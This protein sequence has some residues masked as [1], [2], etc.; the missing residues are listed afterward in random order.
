MRGWPPA[1]A[2]RWGGVRVVGGWE[3]GRGGGGGEGG[4]SEGTIMADS[5]EGGEGDDGGVSFASLF[6]N[7]TNP[8]FL[9]G[10]MVSSLK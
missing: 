4:E 2:G 6:R 5:E 8:V 3:E 7:W 10:Q 9:P 1:L